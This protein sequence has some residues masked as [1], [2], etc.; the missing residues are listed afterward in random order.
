MV[1][2][3]PFGSSHLVAPVADEQLRHLVLV[4]VVPDRAVGRGPERAG[5]QKHLIFLDQLA[6]HLDGLGRRIS[7]VVG[8]EI[9]LAAV[10]PALVVD[11]LV[12]GGHRFA[13]RS[14][15]RG[16]SAVKAGI[17]DLDLGIG[18]ARAVILRGA[19]RSRREERAAEGQRGCGGENCAAGQLFHHDFSSPMLVCLLWSCAARRE[20]R[21]TRGP[22]P[23]PQI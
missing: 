23:S 10:H 3:W 6:R 2:G 8:D 14:V 20:A 1:Q 11:H 17:A 13:D 16:G 7:V 19:G 9:D 4:H 21:I 18:D 12:I 5:I 22:A 15:G